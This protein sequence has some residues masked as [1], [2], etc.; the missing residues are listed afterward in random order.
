M[1]EEED[2]RAREWRKR[3]GE[4]GRRIAGA[5]RIGRTSQINASGTGNTVSSER[6]GARRLTQVRF[7][8]ERKQLATRAGG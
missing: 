6:V 1:D 8:I 4:K 5:N 7:A 2:E 3:K